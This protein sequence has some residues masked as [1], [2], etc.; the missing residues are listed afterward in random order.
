MIR[1]LL[2]CKVNK[3]RGG[4]HFV[5]VNPDRKQKF[6]SQPFWEADFC[7]QQDKPSTMTLIYVYG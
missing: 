7:F 5:K 1:L 6:V 2:L 4:R 3:F